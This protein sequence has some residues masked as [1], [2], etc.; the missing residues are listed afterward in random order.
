MSNPYRTQHPY[1]EYDIQTQFSPD[2][3]IYADN[4]EQVLSEV[5]KDID[6]EKVI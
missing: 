2:K 6:D 3:I 4:L 1:R 5:V